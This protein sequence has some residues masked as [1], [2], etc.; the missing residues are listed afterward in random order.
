MGPQEIGFAAAY[1][2]H[3]QIKYGAN[4]YNNLYTDYERQREA[5]RALAIAEGLSPSILRLSH[6]SRGFPPYQKPRACGK[7]RVMD[8]TNMAYRR[9]ATLRRLQPVT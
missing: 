8:T 4:V 2:A 6:A 9:H 3:R 7:T 1:E 5:L